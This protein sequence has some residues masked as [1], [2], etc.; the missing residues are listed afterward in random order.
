MYDYNY[1]AKLM[2]P[3]TLSNEEQL[4]IMAALKVEMDDFL[5]QYNIEEGHQLAIA[6]F[7]LR[8]AVGLYKG[9]V[10]KNELDDL[11]EYVLDR[12][13]DIPPISPKNRT[14]N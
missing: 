11:F 2:N 13:D 14:L 7:L 4:K 10:D 3:E 9:T 6:G 8:Y 1:L 12:L 5:E